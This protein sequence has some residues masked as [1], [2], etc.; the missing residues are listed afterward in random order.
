MSQRKIRHK[1]QLANPP[2]WFFTEQ[3][4]KFDKRTEPL[5]IHSVNNADNNA[6]NI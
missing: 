4:A 6:N 5:Q 2:K 1:N 3:G